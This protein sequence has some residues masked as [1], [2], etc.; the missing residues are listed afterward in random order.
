MYT[1]CRG[2]DS[3][4]YSQ[5]ID[6]RKKVAA[7]KPSNLFRPSV[8]DEDEKKFCNVNRRTA[9][10]SDFEQALVV[11]LGSE[12]NVT[13]IA[14]QGRSHSDEYVMEYRIQGPM[15]QN[16]LHPVSRCDISLSD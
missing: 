6:Q 7:D 1:D 11:D 14:T 4:P 5:A 10:H 12:K 8:S 3:S 16:F 15:L 2:A 9:E 13:G